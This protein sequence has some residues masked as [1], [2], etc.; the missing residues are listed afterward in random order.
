MKHKTMHTKL[1]PH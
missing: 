1:M